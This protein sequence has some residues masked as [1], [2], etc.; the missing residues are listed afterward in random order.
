M[1][2]DIYKNLHIDFDNPNG[3]PV[4]C[5]RSDN[6]VWQGG[7]DPNHKLKVGQIYNASYIQD[8][9]CHTNVYIEELD[10]EA[11]NSVL[12]RELS[13][14]EL[15]A[16]NKSREKAT[17][18]WRLKFVDVDVDETE[19]VAPTSRQKS[20]LNIVANCRKK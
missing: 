19:V 15:K 4:M 3:R 12:F 2:T 16:Y 11:F 7:G 20:L 18:K 5:V 14:K 10:N 9:G 8:E 13:R 6:E 1:S 17:K